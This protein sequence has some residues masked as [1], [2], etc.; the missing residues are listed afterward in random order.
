MFTFALDATELV[1]D[2]TD[3]LCARSA[4]S[5]RVNLLTTASCS[6]SSSR[7]ISA[8]VMGRGC[9]IGGAVA[10]SVVERLGER[11]GKAWVCGP[12]EEREGGRVPPGEARGRGGGL[13]GWIWE[14]RREADMEVRRELGWPEGGCVEEALLGRGETGTE[15]RSGAMVIENGG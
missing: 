14:A 3:A 4:L 5:S 9:R 8:A 2:A 6:F 11:G 13:M 10:G 7:C 1:V 15:F 12:A